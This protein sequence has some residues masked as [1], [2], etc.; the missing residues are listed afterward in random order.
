[1]RIVYPLLWSTLGRHACREQT[2]H[3]AAALARRGHEVTLLMPRRPRDPLLSADE[4]CRYF[5]VEGALELVQ[6][7]SRWAGEGLLTSL[8]W[9]F[10][11][12]RDPELGGADLVLSRI[13]AM[14]GAGHLS[15]IPFA[16]DHYR[17]WPDD[18]PI[19]RPF[20]RR[21]AAA[22]HCLGI[23][24][25]SEHAAGAYRRIGIDESRLLVA[26][27]GAARMP[28][29]TGEE[30]RDR[31]GLPRSRPIAA[32]AGRI[33]GEKGLDQLL[34][35]ADL[36]RETL[37]LL[38]G[39]EG[40]GP[41]ERSAA[42][43]DNVR[44]VP[45][46]APRDLPVWL[47]AA[48]VLLIPPSRAPLERFRNCV[49]PMKLFAYLAAGRPILAPVSPDTAELL[50][51]GETALLIEPDR[52]EAA[53]AALDRLQHEPGLADRLGGAARARSA[54]LSWDS[55][56]EKIA[57]FLQ[58]RLL[59]AATSRRAARAD[60]APTGSQPAPNLSFAAISESP[61]DS[62]RLEIAQRSL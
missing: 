52:P 14:L 26:H 8:M 5:E 49:L 22:P 21:T 31:L 33:N 28:P 10:E 54:G 23:V 44:L 1:V 30:A 13:P 11:M 45:W 39:S 55:R 35:L 7:P 47:Q 25:H 18:H 53:A 48:D 46:A 2:M 38:V 60:C 42:A 59:A 32:Y 51:D 16:T 50:I 34:A 12:V 24:L 27:N 41:I 3:T 20:L 29:L 37:F 36:R 43:R 57:A 62:I 9:I 58:E 17:L 61:D 15:P 19:C 4:L 40:D 56:A 6:R